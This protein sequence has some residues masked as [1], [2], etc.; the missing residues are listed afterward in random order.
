MRVLGI[1]TCGSEGGVALAEVSEQ[2]MT[3]L[4]ERRLAGRTYSEDLLRA[5]R[6]I[7]EA[8]GLTVAFLDAIVVVHGPGSFTGVRIGLSTAKGLAQA[9]GTPVIGVSRLQVL[10]Q[11]AGMQ[12]AVL[13]AGRG[14]MYFGKSGDESGEALLSVMEIRERINER[15]I[16]CCEDS[17]AQLLPEALRVAAPMAEDALRYAQ[18]RILQRNFNDLA[19]MDAHYLRRSEAEVVARRRA[20]ETAQ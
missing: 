15:E 12:A 11:K 20:S 1:D 8:A 17:T 2:D 13:D 10:A 4:Q 5:I 18:V 19:A 3:V 7:L 9:V 16:A 14:E 6:E